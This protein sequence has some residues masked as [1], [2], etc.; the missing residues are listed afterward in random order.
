MLVDTHAHLHH[1][2]LVERT[3]EVL[4]AAKLAGVGKILTVGVNAADSAAAV[5]F[6]AAREEV[7]AT[8]GLHPHDAGQGKTALDKIAKLARHPKVVAIGECGLDFY[9][10]LSGREEQEKALRFQI[11]LALELNKP[12]VFHVRQA[13]DEFFKILDD[14]PRTR[15][16]VHCFTATRAELDQTLERGLYAAFNGIMTFTKDEFQLEAA[17]QCPA[18]RLLLETDCPFLTPHPKR[19]QVNEPANLKIIAE[20]LAKLRNEPFE[21]L[22]SQTTQNALD[23][24][25]I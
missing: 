20:F 21:A 14:Y 24:F 12:L 22:A 5:E 3:S 19:G 23:L 9:R 15:G 13:F 7:W 2:G 16:V 17:Q 4:D 6:A 11:E 1:E 18:D 10:N 8:V 25:G